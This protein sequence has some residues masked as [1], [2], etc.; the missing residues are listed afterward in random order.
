MMNIK[1]IFL[2]NELSEQ[3]KEKVKS[4]FADVKSFKKGELIYSTDVFPNAIGYVIEGEAVAVT[5]NTGE[6]FMKSFHPGDVFGA[7]AV[8]GDN[9]QF[10]STIIAKTDMKILFI[11]EE[12]LKDIFI[13]VPQ[14][15]LNYITFLSEKIRF[16]N[17]K[18]NIIS[19][20]TAEDTLYKYLCGISQ[21]D[22]FVKLPVSM[23]LL[24]KMLGISRATLYRSFDALESDGRIQRYKNNNIKVIKNEENS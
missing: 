2:L 19:C 10:V 6:V 13:S 16:L 9:Q 22:D 12:T 5:N 8:F 20:T 1:E 17:R 18:L 4:Y 21:G 14:T 23:T 24:S 11:S 7:A 3:E 15:A